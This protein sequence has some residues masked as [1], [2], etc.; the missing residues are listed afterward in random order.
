MIKTIF[1]I[2]MSVAVSA[3]TT[4]LLLMRYSNTAVAKS[5]IAKTVVEV[6]YDQAVSGPTVNGADDTH[7]STLIQKDDPAVDNTRLTSKVAYFDYNKMN[8]DLKHISTV[9]EKF[10]GLMSREITRFKRLKEQNG[11]VS[12][13]GP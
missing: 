2:V 3:C 13:E 9:L 8:R 10:N 1:I 7:R 12:A 6:V 5:E 4:V 11:A